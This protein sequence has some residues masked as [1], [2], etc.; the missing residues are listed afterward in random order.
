[1]E[2]VQSVPLPFPR[3]PASPGPRDVHL[4]PIRTSCATRLQSRVYPH[5]VSQDSW[6]GDTFHEVHEPTTRTGSDRGPGRRPRVLSGIT[7]SDL[8]LVYG[9]SSSIPGWNLEWEGMSKGSY[10]W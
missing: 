6:D 2:S 1:M 5:K 10:S 7:N 3:R 4:D 8:G 9:S